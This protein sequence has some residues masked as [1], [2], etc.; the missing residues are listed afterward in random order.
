MAKIKVPSAD[1]VCG[2]FSLNMIR[3]NYHAESIV[4][5]LLPLQT[6]YQETSKAKFIPATHP[7]LF[8]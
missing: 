5:C 1:T 6:E 7:L 2:K 8:P 3:D 4:P